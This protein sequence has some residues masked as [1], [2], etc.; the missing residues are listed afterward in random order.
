VGQ[1]YNQ[2]TY[3][4][5][6][7]I[8]TSTDGTTWDTQISETSNELY[9]ITYENKEFVAVGDNGTILISSDGKT[10]ITQNSGT[11]NSL[12]EIAYGNNTFVAVGANGTILQSNPFVPPATVLGTINYT[13]SDTGN[14]YVD[15]FTNA[16][17]SGNPAYDTE[18][19]TKGS[20]SITGINPGTYYAVAF[21]STN[22][23]TSYDS[24]IDP[25]G[26]YAGNPLILIS[27]QNATGINITLLN[28]VGQVLSVSPST[29]FS[30]SGNQGGP[31]SPSSTT[32][33]VSNTGGGTLTWS[34]SADQ[35]WV[36]VSP[37]NGT[38]S[39]IVTVSIN[40]N[41]NSLTASPT[42]YT[43]TVTFIS[44]GGTITR[45]VSLAV[46]TPP[47]ST[48]TVSGSISYT[49]SKTGNIYIG[50]FTNSNL[51]G[52]PAYST[53]IS[54]PGSYSISNI[55]P[56]T[57][58]AAAFMS[59][60]G[61]TSYDSAIDPAGQYTGN[62]ITLTSGQNLTGTN[63]TLINP[64]T[65]S[66]LSISGFS[67]IGLAGGPFSPSSTTYSV[68]N[69]GGG[70]L[71]WS[72]SANQNWVTVSPTNGTNSGTVTVSIN[73]N[74][75]SLTTSP[76]PYTSTVTFTSNGGTTTRQVSLTVSTPPVFN[77]IKIYDINGNQLTGIGDVPVDYLVQFTGTYTAGSDGANEETTIWTIN[78]TTGIDTEIY[79]TNSGT[80]SYIWIPRNILSAGATYSITAQTEDSNDLWSTPSTINF[81]T[82]PQPNTI[83]T[84]INPNTG[85]QG[86]SDQ[87]P[88]DTNI[89]QYFSDGILPDTAAM[90]NFNNTPVL[91][92]TSTGDTIIYLGQFTPDT[93]PPAGAAF[94]GVFTTKIKC[95][96]G[97]T[98]T[99]TYIFP[100]NLP[101]GTKWYKYIET[102]P[103]G[104]QWVEYPNAVII[105][106]TV[107]VQLTDGGQGDQDGTENGII[108]DPSGPIQQPIIPISSGGS[109]GV[110]VE[111][112]A[113]VIVGL[114]LLI[115]TIQRKKTKSLSI[116]G[117]KK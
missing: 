115:K 34:V 93:P 21:M 94:D 33:S 108:L 92:E 64:P 89:K 112:I 45:Q 19:S 73:S 80:S 76:T 71:T 74:A 48:A 113:V 44:N 75:N 13:G 46:N 29:G 57:Y 101:A 15:L 66:V 40:S 26:Q 30:S 96:P 72:V 105:G 8:L 106:N 67:S 68:S 7:T 43:S 56:G 117:G 39:G 60:N 100:Q 90:I 54:T 95:T 9:G 17:L 78:D 103:V 12:N 1:G 25:A 16:N 51:S 14:I 61:S 99:V 107:I 50:L 23:S 52:N 4:N 110:P 86:P 38:N 84:T 49:G 104:Q 58:Y 59:T 65:L 27:G 62:P 10:W 32:Y 82:V 31:F 88:T 98:I 83:D 85:A 3:Q 69:S 11:N 41:A 22:G 24:A 77:N 28:P 47:V 20:Y 53:E 97:A 91:V 35:S 36:T 63:I 55:N 114:L 116:P 81:T 37:A 18:I 109:G 6:G 2:S 111:P 79:T 87:V 102:N 42:P 70:T 5:Y